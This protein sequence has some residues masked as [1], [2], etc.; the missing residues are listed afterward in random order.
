MSADP[1]P[2]KTPWST[3]Y[4]RLEAPEAQR[5]CVAG[6]FNDWDPDRH[7]LHRSPSGV[8]ECQFPLPPGRYGY[9]F[10]VDGMP[11]A[12]PRCGA[13]DRT[14]SGAP[15]CILEVPSTGEQVAGG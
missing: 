14:A 10:V 3:I 2:S 5:V 11:C 13:L 8:W 9:H 6:D 1:R 15:R 7:C 4:F 12:D